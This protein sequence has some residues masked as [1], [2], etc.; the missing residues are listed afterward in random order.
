M[1]L[2]TDVE[3]LD[4]LPLLTTPLFTAFHVDKLALRASS[5]PGY[6]YVL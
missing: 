2:I 3:S 4:K 6:R 5:L 1:P